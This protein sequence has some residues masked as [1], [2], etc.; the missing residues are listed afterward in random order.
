[1][2]WATGFRPDYSW[3]KLPVLNRRG[4]LRHDGGAVT[5]ASGLYALGLPMLRTRAST[6]IHAAAADT[7]ALANRLLAELGR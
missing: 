2:V 6:Y 5:D 4:R 7:E 3:L 1:M